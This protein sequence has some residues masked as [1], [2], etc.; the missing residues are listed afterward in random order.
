[1]KSLISYLIQSKGFLCLKENQLINSDITQAITTIADKDGNYLQQAWELILNFV[2]RFERLQESGDGMKSPGASLF[3]LSQIEQYSPT[4]IRKGSYSERHATASGTTS[5]LDQ[6]EPSK[7]NQIF[8][9]SS[10]QSL[11]N[12]AVVDFVRAL[13]KVSMEELQSPDP[14]I[15]CLTKTVEIV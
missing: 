13:C 6:I 14:R 5:I 2:S 8:T 7:M 12:E 4:A 10:Q 3:G 9:A 15:F 11:N 1:M